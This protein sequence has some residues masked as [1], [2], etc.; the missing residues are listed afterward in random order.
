MGSEYMSF[1]SIKSVSQYLL[2]GTFSP[3]IFK[4]IID[5]H[6]LNITLSFVVW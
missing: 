2:M 3:I 1:S 4:V 5:R 6:V